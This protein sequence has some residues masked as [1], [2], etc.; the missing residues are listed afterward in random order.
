MQ[1]AAP[2][3]DQFLAGFGL[4]NP[5]LERIQAGRNS[6]VWRV[7]V[8]DATYIA[9]EYF[10][11][12]ADPRDRLGTEYGFLQVLQSQ[13]IECVP[14]PLNQ[15][16]ASD[17]ALYSHLPGTPVATIEADHIQ[18]CA[19]FIAR[20]NQNPAAPAAQALPLASEACLTPIE[21]L[22]RV[23]SRLTRLE[24]A[25]AQPEAKPQSQ[26][27]RAAQTFLLEA[28]WP[29]YAQLE[30]QIH[31]Q[32][33]PELER[34][35]SKAEQILSPSDFGFH[36][37]LAADGQLYF[38]DFEYA[39]WDDPAKL[40]C[41]FSCQ[42]QRPVSPAQGQAFAT[43]LTRLLPAVATA[44]A[45]AKALLPLYRLKWCCILLNEFRASDQQRRDHAVGERGDRLQNQ[46]HKAQRYFP[47]HLQGV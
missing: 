26:L 12:P 10:R 16:P 30:Q 47:Q 11:H 17:R 24:A 25:L 29:T 23:K 40:L 22:N 42:P 19:A 36:N 2:E 18:Q 5:T 20:I 37:I 28:L 32:L 8:A 1:V 15:D 46:L 33:H 43:Q 31:H 34:A 3:L 6:R 9:K 45:R 41:D 4:T 44:Q 35:L 27:Y 39:G 38:L 21:H 7:I 14:R 13:G